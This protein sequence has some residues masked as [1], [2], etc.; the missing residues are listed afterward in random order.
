MLRS[1]VSDGSA[2]APFLFLPP[3]NP[4]LSPPPSS[5]P[6]SPQRHTKAQGAS[7]PSPASPGSVPVLVPPNTPSQFR[8]AEQEQCSHCSP[9]RSPSLFSA[10]PGLWSART[11]TGTCLAQLAHTLSHCTALLLL[12]TAAAAATSPWGPIHPSILSSP[13][14]RAP[15]LPLSQSL[16]PLHPRRQNHHSLPHFRPV[17]SLTVDEAHPL[18]PLPRLRLPFH[19][20]PWPHALRDHSKTFP[21][22]AHNT[23]S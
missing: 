4:I 2:R 16:F 1:Q 13:S 6:S 3:Q 8:P 20:S 5:P 7:Q 10:W 22:D 9:T 17:L 21:P 19:A 15:S 11:C 12:G 14:C 23:T 18:N